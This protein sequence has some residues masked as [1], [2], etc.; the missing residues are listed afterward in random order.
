MRKNEKL[1][2]DVLLKNKNDFYKNIDFIYLDLIV[3][4]V[5]KTA[6]LIF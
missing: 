3:E 5:I 6:V 4:W 1:L 2:V